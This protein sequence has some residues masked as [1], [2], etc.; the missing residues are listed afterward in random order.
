LILPITQAVFQCYVV[1]Y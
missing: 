1:S